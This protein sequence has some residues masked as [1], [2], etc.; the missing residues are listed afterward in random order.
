MNHWMST[1]LRQDPGSF[2]MYRAEKSSLVLSAV[3]LRELQTSRH[4]K[5]F[6]ISSELE[7]NN[8]INVIRQIPV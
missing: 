1:L 4:S 5:A 2:K 8:R 7:A 6:I 3:K